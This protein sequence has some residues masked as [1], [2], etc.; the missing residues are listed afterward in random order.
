MGAKVGETC[1]KHGISDATHYKWKATYGG[2]K[3]RNSSNCVT[4]R[5]NMVRLKKMY[6]ELA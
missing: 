1:R 3:C 6:A 4:Y 5:L 2:I